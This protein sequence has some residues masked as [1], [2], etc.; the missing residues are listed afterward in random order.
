M[1]TFIASFYKLANAYMTTT[2]KALPKIR[3]SHCFLL[4]VIYTEF[5]LSKL[6]VYSKN[7]VELVIKCR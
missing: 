7:F 1:K 6:I 4:L 3:I 2:K 5:Y